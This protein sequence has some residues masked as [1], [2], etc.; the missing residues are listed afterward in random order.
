M[1]LDA[2]F[3]VL[4]D[5]GRLAIKLPWWMGK[6]PRRDVPYESKRSAL[7]AGYLLLDKI[8]WV[9]GGEANVH[10]SVWPVHPLR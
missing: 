2:Q 9:N 5:S 7:D 1:W 3:P 8:I 10:V 6:K 4:I